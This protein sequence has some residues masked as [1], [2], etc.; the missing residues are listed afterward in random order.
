MTELAINKKQA[1]FTLIELMVV[2]AIIGILAS[3]AI[4]IYANYSNKTKFSELIQA[5]APFKLAV[6]LCAN[7]QGDL[8]ACGNG[9]NGVPEAFSASNAETGY[10]ANINV[11]DNGT[12]TATSQRINVN[13]QNAFTYILTPSLQ[14]NGQVTWQQSGNCS[15]AHLC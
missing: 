13:D 9:K 10:V 14:P 12:I 3:L 2:I 11:A 15:E 6:E 4:P 1:G 5:T 7:E 8:K